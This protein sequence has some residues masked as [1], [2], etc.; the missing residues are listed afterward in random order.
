MHYDTGWLGG[1]HVKAISTLHHYTLRS[2]FLA[3]LNVPDAFNVTKEAKH[4]YAIRPLPDSSLYNF[5][6]LTHYPRDLACGL[7]GTRAKLTFRSTTPMI[8]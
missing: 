4:R 7:D 5:D 8:G 6:S 1:C 2:S 3:L